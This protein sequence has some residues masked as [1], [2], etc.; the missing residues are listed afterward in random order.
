MTGP[1]RHRT[2]LLHAVLLVG[3]ALG[4]VLQQVVV[5]MHLAG[6]DHVIGSA[7]GEHVH[8]RAAGHHEHGFGDVTAPQH[9][10]EHR[11]G[12]VPH[13]IEDHLDDG[14]ET[15]V[16]PVQHG[17][18]L[19][20]GLVRGTIALPAEPVG[21]LQ[22]IAALGPRGPPGGRTPPARAPPVVS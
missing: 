2:T 18:A 13:P 4:F 16:A 10:D 5:P 11:E 19:V 6:H 1:A 22:W 15:A 21:R 7:S 9:A 3:V 20:L 12:H 17:P 8:T 14:G